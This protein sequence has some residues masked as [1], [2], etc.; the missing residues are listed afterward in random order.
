MRP[1]ERLARAV[2]LLRGVA[3]ATRMPPPGEPE[4]GGV[5]P[6]RRDVPADPRAELLVAVLLLGCAACGVAF[7]VAIGLDASPQLQGLAFGGALVLLA[8]ALGV[9][10]RRVVVQETDVEERPRL[11]RPEEHEPLAREA[12]SA[13]AGISR[14]RLLAGSA[15]VAG[16]GLAAG[17]VAPATSLGPAVGD[18]LEQTPWRRGRRLVD[19]E[20]RPLRLADVA[21]GS[22]VTAFPEG[23]DR[24]ELGSPVVVVRLDPA[25][26]QLPPGREGWA[27]QG[28]LAYSKI[29]THA[30]CAIALYR[31]PKFDPQQPGPALACPCHYSVFDVARGAAVTDG[32]AG[33]PLPQL[34]LTLGP[35]GELVAAGG[36]SGNVGPAWW[37]VR[38]A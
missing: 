37:G 7:A 28:V 15:A 3:R 31:H 6:R 34:P 5:D 24:R 30:G 23:A 8:A 29:C 38:K 33:R 4:G 14:R 18:R 20:G 21:E 32:P 25:T 27:P 13:A 22:F 17:I 1:A 2:A 16:A 35:G 10:G 19:E 9:A 36:L 11:D 12:A 26:L